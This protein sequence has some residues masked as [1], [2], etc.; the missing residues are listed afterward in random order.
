MLLCFK[1]ASDTQKDKLENT[2]DIFFF[3]LFCAKF[4]FCEFFLEKYTDEDSVQGKKSDHGYENFK[5]CQKPLGNIRI[6]II[7]KVYA[8]TTDSSQ[9]KT[10]EVY[11]NL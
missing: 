1:V 9:E 2:S 11:S 4:K 10:E 7:I 6:I 5:Y 8:P 3:S